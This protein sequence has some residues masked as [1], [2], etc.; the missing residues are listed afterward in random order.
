MFPVSLGVKMQKVNHMKMIKKLTTEKAALAE[1]FKRL[2]DENATRKISLD[3][4][5]KRYQLLQVRRVVE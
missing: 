5:M 4:N 2:K 3:A 1:K